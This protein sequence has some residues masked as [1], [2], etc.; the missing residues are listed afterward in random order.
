MRSTGGI[1]RGKRD[2]LAMVKRVEKGELAVVTRYGNPVA[3]MILADRMEVM[4]KTIELLANPMF[5]RA[6]AAECPGTP[7]AVYSIDDIPY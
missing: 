5:T 1:T 4:L 3:Y 7:G 6:L 2:F